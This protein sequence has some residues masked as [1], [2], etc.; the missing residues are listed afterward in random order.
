MLRLGHHP[1]LAAPAFAGLIAQFLE[2]PRRA[3]AFFG[4]GLGFSQF[5]CNFSFEPG[6]AGQAEDVFDT[7]GLA[8][9]H[10]FFTAEAGI[11]PKP[12]FNLRP[13]LPDLRHHPG[14]LVLGA[15]RGVDVRGPQFRQKQLPAAKNIKRQVAVALVIA[16]EEAAFL[17]AVDR[18]V[19]GVEIED[20]AL[21]RR[22]LAFEKEADK[23]PLHGLFVHAELAVTVLFGPWRVLEPV[24]RGFPGQD[25][26]IGA[27]GFELARDKAKHRIVTQLIVIVEVLIAE[28][29]AM[30][31]LG[32]QRFGRMLDPVL[33]PA[34]LE[35]GCHLPRQANTAIR[36]PQKQRARIRGYRPAVER[37]CDFP[38]SQTGEIERILATLRLHRGSPLL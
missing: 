16:M 7:I 20:D 32:N 2:Y 28:R 11:G 24:Q 10:E 17:I 5:F 34:I 18:I 27:A 15:G 23:Q 25:R 3:A 13:A 6:V 29:N 36:L 4:L 9:S 35:T 31:T 14:D 19:R 30:D 12:D 8:P 26:A 37:R 1:A 33:R 38:A 22:G 21:G